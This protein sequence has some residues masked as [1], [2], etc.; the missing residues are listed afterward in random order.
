MYTSNPYYYINY[1]G[2][3][4]EYDYSYSQTMNQSPGF[5]YYDT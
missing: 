3:Y 1:M 5:N 2:Y 4:Q